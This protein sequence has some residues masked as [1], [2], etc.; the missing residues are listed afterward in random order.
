MNK[1]EPHSATR[2]RLP[3]N[4]SSVSVGSRRSDRRERHFRTQ[5]AGMPGDGNRLGAR[6]PPLH[7]LR[8][9]SS[10]ACSDK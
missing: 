10:P 3:A 4:I 2:S 5:R 6:M 8:I 1:G 9:R 7:T